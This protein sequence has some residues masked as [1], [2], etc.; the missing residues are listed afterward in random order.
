MSDFKS[1]SLPFLSPNWI[2]T[3]AV[4][5]FVIPT[6]VIIVSYSL[7]IRKLY[8]E[9][10]EKSEAYQV[11]I[12][13]ISLTAAFLLCWWP[14]CIYL[15]VKWKAGLGS[16][17]FYFGLLNSLVNPILFIFLNASLKAKVVEL[18]RCRKV[19]EIRESF[20]FYSSK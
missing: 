6:V 3:V 13:M 8:E 7:I 15:S 12:T 5:V 10:T 14:I 2:W 9:S 16:R 1:C 17:G 19:Q 20:S 4:T 11:T 18:F